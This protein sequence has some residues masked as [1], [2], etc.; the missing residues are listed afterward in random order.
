[1]TNKPASNMDVKQRNRSNTLRCILTQD[2]ISQ[3]ELTQR[4]GLSWPTVLQNVKELTQLGLIQEAGQYESTGGRKAKAYAPIRDARLAVGLDLTGNHISIVLI[5]LCGQ[6]VRYK[7]KISPFSLSQEYMQTLGELVRQF[8]AENHAQDRILGIGISLPGIV[9]EAED[10][11]VYSHILNVRD[12]PTSTFCQQLPYPCNFINDANA[13][14]LAEIYG[15]PTAKNLIYLSLSN[16]VGGAILIHDS[17]YTGSNLRAGEFGHNT[18]VPHG[19]TCYCGKKGCVDAYCSAKVLSEYT[20]GNLPD[21]FQ[22]LRE[23][24]PRLLQVWQEYLEY[25]AIAINNLRMSFDCSVIA[26]GY[27]GAFLEEFGGPLGPLLKERNTFQADASY[28]KPC[29]YK[30]EASAVG[31]ALVQVETFIQNL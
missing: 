25:L 30:L 31:A 2:H 8:I 29:R 20:K 7:R 23:G 19:R 21:F 13:A 14:G 17:L 6:L 1:M 5:D 3:M 9:S 28:F 12:V 26:G 11:L 4:L 18:L 24:N 22:G 15:N 10:F 16:S 27:V